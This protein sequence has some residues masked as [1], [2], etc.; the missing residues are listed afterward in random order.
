MKNPFSTPLPSTVRSSEY[1]F[2]NETFDYPSTVELDN[3]SYP[4]MDG[5]ENGPSKYRST[6]G[7]VH[8]D[9][10]PAYAGSTALAWTDT[11]GI[12]P[13]YSALPDDLAFPVNAGEIT[14]T[15]GIIASSG[16]VAG[17]TPD[18]WTGDRAALH[19]PTPGTNGPVSGGPDYGQALNAAYH[20]ANAAVFNAAAAESAMVAAV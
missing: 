4:V 3:T 5:V 17:T 19:K 8:Q 9:S 7:N 1:G 12:Q 14:G 6:V 15:D 10:N 20:A 11:P 13:G 2:P 18:V 16:P